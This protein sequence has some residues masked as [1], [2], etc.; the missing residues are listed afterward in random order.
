MVVNLLTSYFPV[1]KC[2]HRFIAIISKCYEDLKMKQTYT[3]I[4]LVTFL[5]M[6]SKTCFKY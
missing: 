4:C 2:F 1:K 6:L 5:K 3:G